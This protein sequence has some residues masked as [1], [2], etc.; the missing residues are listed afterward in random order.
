MAGLA[1]GILGSYGATYIS[2][3]VPPSELADSRASDAPIRTV[4]VR[5]RD[6][7]IQGELWMYPGPVTQNRKAE[8]AATTVRPSSDELH[9]ALYSS[10]FSDVN[11][12]LLRLLV[13]GRRNGRVRI[14]DMQPRIIEKRLPG[15]GASLLGPGAQGTGQSVSIGFNLDE[16]QPVARKVNPLGDPSAKE[17][18]G[19]SFFADSS[20]ELGRVEQEI[21]RIAAR[22]LACD[23]KWALL[24]KLVVPDVDPSTTMIEVVDNGGLPFRTTALLYDSSGILPDRSRYSEIYQYELNQL[25][26]RSAKFRRVNNLDGW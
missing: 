16:D 19:S 5:D 6:Q 18:F 23:V 15:S 7:G 22:T 12:T 8:V 4:I 14:I 26:Y 13:E 2:A 17:Y 9:D 1:S 10:G 24:V 21:Y 11:M 20:T 3:L 25:D